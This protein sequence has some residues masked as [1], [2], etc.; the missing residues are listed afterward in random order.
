MSETYN[1]LIANF[2]LWH[3]SHTADTISIRSTTNIILK[4]IKTT[5]KELCSRKSADQ[6]MSH[7]NHPF[8]H[9]IGWTVV[10]IEANGLP[11]RSD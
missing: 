2:G 1:V 5:K 7:R 9:K 4:I 6:Q 3:L 11:H 10:N 8:S